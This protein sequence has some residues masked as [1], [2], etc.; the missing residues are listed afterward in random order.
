MAYLL[1]NEARKRLYKLIDEIALHH[2]PTF[3]KGKRNSAVLVS[4]SYW[5]DLQETLLV[6]SNKQLS[7]SIIRGLNTPFEK[8]LTVLA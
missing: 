6:A 5:E 4:I 1:A 3:I 2:E 7:D 8:C